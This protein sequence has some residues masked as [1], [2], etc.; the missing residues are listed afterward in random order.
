MPLIGSLLLLGC[1]SFSLVLLA[2]TAA[3]KSN[4][5]TKNQALINILFYII[6]TIILIL[7]IYNTSYTCNT[8]AIINVKLDYVI[9]FILSILLLVGIVISTKNNSV[10]FKHK[11]FEK[12]TVKLVNIKREND[13]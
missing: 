8:F 6:S 3:E 1:G 11:K 9:F 7:F 13:E 4:H 5:P 2:F 12:N 10:I